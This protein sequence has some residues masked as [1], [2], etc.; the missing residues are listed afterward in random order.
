M[1]LMFFRNRQYILLERSCL[2]FFFVSPQIIFTALI[3]SFICGVVT[4][5]E[6]Y[7]ECLTKGNHDLKVLIKLSETILRTSV[8]PS[9][10]LRGILVKQHEFKKLVN[11]FLR[12][13]MSPLFLHFREK[14]CCPHKT[15]LVRCSVVSDCL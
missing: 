2:P 10:S 8:S 14:D 7:S 13:K 4:W 3:S 11:W 15:V 5:S 1:L 9:L 12:R 6:H